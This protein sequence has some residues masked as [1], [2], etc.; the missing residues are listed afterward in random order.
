MATYR[1]AV[2]GRGGRTHAASGRI[3]TLAL[4]RTALAQH[5][6]KKPHTQAQI[7]VYL[8]GTWEAYE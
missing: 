3:S 1:I 5:Q 2:R 4:A 8:D 7:E 6:Q